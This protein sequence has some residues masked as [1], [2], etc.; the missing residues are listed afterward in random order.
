MCSRAQARMSLQG[1]GLSLSSARNAKTALLAKA[2]VTGLA[3]NRKRL[4]QD[5]VLGAVGL[6]VI[7]RTH[8]GQEE[9]LT[10]HSTVWLAVPGRPADG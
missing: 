1:T 5:K 7:S 8:R 4:Q 2:G 6:K 3:S 10:T 9:R